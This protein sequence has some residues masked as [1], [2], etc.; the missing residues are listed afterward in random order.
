MDRIEFHVE[1][2]IDPELLFMK[3]DHVTAIVEHH[4]VDAVRKA[5]AERDE[6]T[7]A[8]VTVHAEV[9]TQSAELFRRREFRVTEIDLDGCDH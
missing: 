5:L 1:F 2:S 3:R 7:T 4:A 8:C 6:E 9:G